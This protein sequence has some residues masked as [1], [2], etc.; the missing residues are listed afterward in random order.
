MAA[1]LDAQ[2][3]FVNASLS[4][5]A[6]V[7]ATGLF[8]Q[9]KASFF[10]TSPALVSCTLCLIPYTPSLPPGS[11][12][13]VISTHNASLLPS[14]A[15]CPSPPKSC[16]LS[17]QPFNASAPVDAAA[18]ALS[19]PPSATFLPNSIPASSI[20]TVLATFPQ[21]PLPSGASFTAVSSGSDFGCGLASAATQCAAGS[22]NVYC[23]GS[24]NLNSKWCVISAFRS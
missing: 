6:A 13:I 2:F 21:A 18:T 17:F 16:P 10:P 24:Y 11:H 9:L 8:V 1:A 19:I 23:W 15:T 5:S 22:S 20:R 3:S 14:A 4:T 7:Y 12:S